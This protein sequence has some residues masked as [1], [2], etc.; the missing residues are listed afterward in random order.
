MDRVLIVGLAVT[1]LLSTIAPA[2]DAAKPGVSKRV[3]GKTA[4]GQSV[5]EFTLRAG[6]FM[7]RIIT[8]GAAVS[9]LVVP[10]RLGKPTDVVLGFDDMAGWQ[11]KGN[12]Y[13]GC[14]VGRVANRIA[15]G[16][17]T[18]GGHEYT[19]SVNNAPNAL[20]GGVRGFDKVVWQAEEI[21]ASAPSV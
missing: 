9:E 15:K 6:P 12:P 16:K 18:L 8:Y 11:S 17:F 2:D 1:L 19:L 14:I 4:D 20:H 13:F 7:A 5:D 10:D 21:Q 3:Y